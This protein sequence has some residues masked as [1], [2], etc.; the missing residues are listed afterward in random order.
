MG[1]SGLINKI[2]GAALVILGLIWIFFVYNFDALNH[3]ITRFEAK[4]IL[5]FALGLIMLVNGVRIFLRKY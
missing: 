5:G 3:R 2:K 4:A 1:K